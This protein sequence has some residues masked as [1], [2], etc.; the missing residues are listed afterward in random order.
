MEITVGKHSLLADAVCD[1]DLE[2]M[3]CH[4]VH[5]FDLLNVRADDCLLLLEHSDCSVHL[6][7]HQFSIGKSERLINL[8]LNFG[9]H[10]KSD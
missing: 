4:F 2:Q 3:V 1:E 7:V 5:L 10:T 9:G 8:L 6:D